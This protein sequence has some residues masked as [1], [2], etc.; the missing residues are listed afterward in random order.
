M[1]FK[2]FQYF[3][4]SNIHLASGLWGWISAEPDQPGFDSSK[5]ITDLLICWNQANWICFQAR[6]LLLAGLVKLT[7]VPKTIKFNQVVQDIQNLKS[8][9]S[10]S[11]NVS[12]FIRAGKGPAG[13]SKT[14]RHFFSFK[15]V[16]QWYYRSPSHLH[17]ININSLSLLT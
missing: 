11:T 10:W 1:H 7:S 12:H 15:K 13:A 9:H 8:H 14:T 6:K 16:K 3:V 4:H 5:A 2:Q 17:K